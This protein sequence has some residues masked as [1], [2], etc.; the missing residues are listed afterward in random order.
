[1]E[2]EVLSARDKKN[3]E[4]ISINEDFYFILERSFKVSIV[5]HRKV[6]NEAPEWILIINP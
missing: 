3:T 5:K 2:C 1:M 4:T 6:T